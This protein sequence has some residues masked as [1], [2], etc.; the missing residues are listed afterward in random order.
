D[1]VGLLGR[2]QDLGHHC[3]ARGIVAVRH[4]S[5]P[6]TRVVW[7]LP[8][9]SSTRRASPGPNTCLEPSPS[10]ISSWPCRMITNCRRGAG[11]QSRNRA[12]GHTRNDVWL[13]GDPFSQSVFLSVSIGSIRP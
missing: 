13:V 5:L 11:C 2:E 12:T 7:P 6:T 1:R 10:P 4:A 9:V 3:C 8:V